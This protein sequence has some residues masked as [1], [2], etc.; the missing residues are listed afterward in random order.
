MF[1]KI[2]KEL[3]ATDRL[4]KSESIERWNWHHNYKCATARKYRSKKTSQLKRQESYLRKSLLFS[5]VFI[6]MFS[7]ER[8]RRRL[9]EIQLKVTGEA[10]R[11]TCTRFFF[12]FFF[13]FT[14]FLA[15]SVQNGKLHSVKAWLL[16]VFSDGEQL[17]LQYYWSSEKHRDHTALTIFLVS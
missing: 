1:S 5:T 13:I 7:K 2:Y 12:F 14:F 9:F 8:A 6:P 17:L 4:G 11:I 10:M 15:I 3:R 16:L